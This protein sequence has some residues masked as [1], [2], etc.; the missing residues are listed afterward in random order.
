MV[1]DA[2][3]GSAAIY[4]DDSGLGLGVLRPVP[5]DGLTKEWPARRRPSLRGSRCPHSL[6]MLRFFR[7]RFRRSQAVSPTVC[8]YD[9]SR[10]S[11][12]TLDPTE[13]VTDESEKDD[14]PL[15]DSMDSLTLFDEISQFKT[16]PRA[17]SSLEDSSRAAEKGSPTDDAAMVDVPLSPQVPSAVMTSEMTE[18]TKDKTD[19]PDDASLTSLYVDQSTHS[20]PSDADMP[21][22]EALS[23]PTKTRS[24]DYSDEAPSDYTIPTIPERSDLERVVM[25]LP[26][27]P[28]RLSTPPVLLHPILD[29]PSDVS[30]DDDDLYVFADTESAILESIFRT[31]PAQSSSRDMDPAEV[32]ARSAPNLYRRC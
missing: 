19:P 3:E 2:A 23:T 5:N 31:T 6:T 26:H 22:D 1:H 12:L 14:V 16:S 18:P 25:S 21:Y 20:P 17:T 32:Q 13:D 15:L 7:R 24:A 9:A 28:V 30:D 11:F 29:C 27:G 4:L 8:F 10:K